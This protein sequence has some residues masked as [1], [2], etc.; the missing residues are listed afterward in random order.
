[1]NDKG[2]YKYADNVW[3]SLEGSAT[4]IYPLDDIT[5]TNNAF[6]EQRVKI[7]VLNL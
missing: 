2:T 1:M 6:R 7:L 5:T 3:T 4:Y